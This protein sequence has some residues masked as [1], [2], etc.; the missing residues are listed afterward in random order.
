MRL[1]YAPQREL[2]R[3][4]PSVLQF[5]HNLT[6]TTPLRT[7]ISFPKHDLEL[8]DTVYVRKNDHSFDKHKQW[9]T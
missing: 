2:P 7:W 3:E 6:L 1:S 4:D 9:D 8:H 5:I